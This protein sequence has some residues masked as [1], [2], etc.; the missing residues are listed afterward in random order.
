[1]LHASLYAT[2]R[3]GASI[4]AILFPRSFS[5]FH[6]RDRGLL[7]QSLAVHLLLKPQ[8][9]T[10]MTSLSST[11]STAS[12][13]RSVT[14]APSA[15]LSILDHYLRRPSG[16]TRVLGTLLG[17]RDGSTTNVLS[18]FAVS[19]SERSPESDAADG[20]EGGESSGGIEV[21]VDMDYHRATYELHRRAHPKEVIVGWYST[22]PTD[23]SAASSKSDI[24][25]VSA[26][27]HNFYQ[28][29]AGQNAVHVVVEPAGVRAY[30]SAP[31]GVFPRPENALFTS[32]P[33]VLSP[34]EDLVAAQKNPQEGGDID[35]L[36]ASLDNVNGLL[37][38]VL[39]YVRGVLAGDIP[40]DKALGRYLLSALVAPPAA[41]ATGLQDTLMVSYLAHLVRAQAEVAARLAL[42]AAQ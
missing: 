21:A 3:G 34:S 12:L 19:H 15:L 33:V 28:Q 5:I 25:E 16:Q 27:V 29:E 24:D 8:N 42:V 7:C 20:T 4:N 30:V 10:N 18:A 35:V 26:L 38:R 32:L 22:S 39:E 23:S 41:A 40:G 31:V 13:S 36:G 1:M 11:P 37:D 6:H 14:L 9:H 17:T 2:A